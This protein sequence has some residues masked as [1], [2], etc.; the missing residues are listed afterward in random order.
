[1]DLSQHQGRIADMLEEIARIDQVETPALE[2]KHVRVALNE[3][4][5]G[6]AGRRRKLCPRDLESDNTSSDGGH[7]ASENPQTAADFQNRHRRLYVQEL[8]KR[9]VGQPV[10]LD[11]PLLFRNTSAVDVR[12]SGHTAPYMSSFAI[13]WT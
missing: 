2:R 12:R 10:Q 13:R 4:N 7:A 1:M 8:D 6:R 5:A 3:G 11:Q 9:V